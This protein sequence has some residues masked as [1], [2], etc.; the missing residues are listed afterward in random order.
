[1]TSTCRY[2]G[3]RSSGREPIEV[4]VCG[5]SGAWSSEYE[6]DLIP[7]RNRDRP[8]W[9]LALRWIRYNLFPVNVPIELRAICKA[10]RKRNGGRLPASLLDIERMR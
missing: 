3:S 6:P 9:L 2:C 5:R 10:I 8:A 4:C 1:M 7:S